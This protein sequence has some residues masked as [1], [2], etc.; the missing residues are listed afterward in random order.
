MATSRY[1]KTPI[2]RN[3]FLFKLNSVTK[4]KI[5]LTYYASLKYRNLSDESLQDLEIQEVT[6]AATDTLMGLAQKF[7]D[8]PSY[9][10]VIAL[11]NNIGSEADIPVGQQLV[12]ATPLSALLPELDL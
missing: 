12:I 5:D 1:R 4:K 9:W 8:S 6:F 7:Y 10:W 11:L 3:S 2:E